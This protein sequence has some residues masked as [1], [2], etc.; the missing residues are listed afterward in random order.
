MFQ[1]RQAL[2]IVPLDGHV[3]RNTRRP[4]V[5]TLAE[6]CR[7]VHPRIRVCMYRACT[8]IQIALSF[9]CACVYQHTYT[10]ASYTV[11]RDIGCCCSCGS[12][13]MCASPPTCRQR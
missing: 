13:V 9:A 3:C 1:Q 10:Y 7:A 6:S 8:G 4:C 2:G 11:I 12:T 5:S